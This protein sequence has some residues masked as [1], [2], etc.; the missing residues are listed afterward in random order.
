M[1]LTKCVTPTAPTSALAR[2]SG[3]LSVTES[4]LRALRIA[5]F[6]AVLPLAFALAHVGPVSAGSASTCTPAQKAKAAKAL[7]TFKRTS[8]ARR[9]AYFRTHKSARARRAFTNRQRARLRVL[10]RAARCRIVPPPS[11]PP[12]PAPTT[13]PAP[14]PVQAT[15]VADSEVSADDVARVS[16]ALAVANGYFHTKLARELPA[17]T[18]SVY[19]DL[20]KLAR[21]YAAV[22]QIGLE[23]ARR[24]WSSGAVAV[25]R[26]RHLFVYVGGETWRVIRRGGR[27][28]IIAHEAFHILQSE[29]AGRDAAAPSTGP[30]WLTEGS[31]DLVATE[32]LSVNRLVQLEDAI[33]AWHSDARP[34]SPPLADLESYAAFVPENHPFGVS[35][36]AADR[37]VQ[38]GIGDTAFI[39][40]YETVG[41]GTP[42]RDA[43]KAAFL[44]SLEAFY[45]DFEAYRRS[46]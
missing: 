7:R 1:C 21:A 11:A 22:A 32:I 27:L 43:F 15:F 9:R 2:E 35:A 12:T 6:A 40:F 3:S 5:R 36:L 17:V 33:A 8:A 41:R 4:R 39:A 10:E 16:D 20:E 45:G 18:V 31:A 19:A 46:T 29:L 34:G 38:G 42:W 24:L 28:K 30:A 14:L 25:A 37:L 26:P 13:P 23:D 44:R